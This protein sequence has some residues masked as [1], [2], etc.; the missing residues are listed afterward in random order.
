[1]KKYFLALA[2]FSGTII[3][4]GLFGLP[5]VTL[6][7]GVVPVLFYFALITVVMIISHLIFG[8]ICLRTLEQRRLP[9]YTEIYLGKKY[10]I[11]PAISNSIGLFGANLAYIII[12]G[13]FL[14]NLLLPVF[15]GNELIYLLIFF[16]TG[17]FIIYLGSKAIAR[18]ELLSLII[19]LVIFLF[20]FIKGSSFIEI[21]NFR[22]FTADF[23]SILLPYGVILFSLSGM[24]IVPEAREILGK[25]G[26]LLKSLLITGTLLPAIVYLFFIVLI[27]GTSGILTTED[28]LSG[29]QP[30]LG[31][32]ILI[33]G[34]LFGIITTF[35]SY[36]SIGL[37]L[38]NILV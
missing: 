20:I 4:V 8:E 17:S 19:F 34:F 18:S 32:N 5:Y 22:L 7:A 36:I 2:T 16:T 24:S 30:I 12:G 15:G 13:G 29:L 37:T 31:P 38:K 26:K 21:D 11:I 28:A 35:T 25:N 27:L 23:K 10:K 3:G 33:V 6:K 14:G 9:G 1:M